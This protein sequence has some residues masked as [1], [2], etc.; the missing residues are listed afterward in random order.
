MQGVPVRT[1]GLSIAIVVDF[2]MVVE[3][4]MVYAANDLLVLNLHFKMKFDDAS[5]NLP[6]DFEV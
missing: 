6:C 1:G 5:V 2:D 3:G 4:M